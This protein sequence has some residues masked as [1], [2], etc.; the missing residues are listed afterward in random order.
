MSILRGDVVQVI[1]GTKTI[2]TPAEVNRLGVE[3]RG[4]LLAF[5]KATTSCFDPANPRSDSIECFAEIVVHLIQVPSTASGTNSVASTS[6]FS[7]Y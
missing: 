5:C 6:E 2:T 3:P 7:E 1:S 4:I